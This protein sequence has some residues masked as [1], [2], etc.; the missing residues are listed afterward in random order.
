MKEKSHIEL[1][2]YISV[3]L[4][5]YMSAL[6]LSVCLPFFPVSFFLFFPLSL[7]RCVSEAVYIPVSLYV[8]PSA[9][10]SVSLSLRSRFVSLKYFDQIY[11]S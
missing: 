4:C 2:L 6:C 9:S 1:C 8:F 7:C 3:F 11:K 10:G 5:L